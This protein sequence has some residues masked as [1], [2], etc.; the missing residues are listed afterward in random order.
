MR[1]P[2]ASNTNDGDDFW[3][4]RRHQ[5]R[6][7]VN[8]VVGIWWKWEKGRMED[9]KS[10]RRFFFYC[11]KRATIICLQREKLSRFSS[12]PSLCRCRTGNFIW[13]GK[14]WKM[15]F[16]SFFFRAHLFKCSF[17]IHRSTP[18]TVSDYIIC[19]SDPHVGCLRLPFSWRNSKSSLKPAIQRHTG[20][21]TC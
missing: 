13:R 16:F 9:E 2:R 7:R 18:Q 17:A 11:V 4:L 12:F 19:R 10:T 15:F 3:L 21:T 6:T 5:K 20:K 1:M 14:V 8:K